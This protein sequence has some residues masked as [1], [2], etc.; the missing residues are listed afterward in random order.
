MKIK[1]KKLFKINVTLFIIL[2]LTVIAVVVYRLIN[3]IP[4]LEYRACKD[5]MSQLAM[6]QAKL[7]LKT[8]SYS[9][10]IK[11]LSRDGKMHFYHNCPVT[12]EEYVVELLDDGYRVICKNHKLCIKNNIFIKNWGQE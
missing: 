1:N 4:P 11:Q 8:G 3:P 12:E 6:Y 10:D 5:R 9:A 2:T 7:K